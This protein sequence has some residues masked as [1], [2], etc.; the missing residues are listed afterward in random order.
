MEKGAHRWYVFLIPLKSRLYIE[1]NHSCYVKCWSRSSKE[2]HGEMSSPRMALVHT[3]QQ[4]ILQ[5]RW[6]LVWTAGPGHERTACGRSY[7][8]LEMRPKFWMALME[9]CTHHSRPSSTPLK[10]GFSSL[11]WTVWFLQT[12]TSCVPRCAIQD[13]TSKFWGQWA[14]Y[15]THQAELIL[16]PRRKVEMDI[17]IGRVRNT[18]NGLNILQPVVF[19]IPG[20]NFEG[21]RREIELGWIADGPTMRSN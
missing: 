10:K 8:I 11:V 7:A 21:Y 19:E 17:D 14:R 6:S 12:T 9:N 5:R 16:V 4:S 2:L 13:V 3:P 18:R 15:W 20:S 1:F